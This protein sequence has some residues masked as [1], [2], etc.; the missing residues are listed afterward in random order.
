MGQKAQHILVLI[1]NLEHINVAITHSFKL[2]K[3]FKAEVAFSFFQAENPTV[4]NSLPTDLIEQLNPNSI[5]YKLIEFGNPEKEPNNSIQQLNAIFLITQ[6]PINRINHSY[7][8]NRIFKWLMDARIPTIVVSEKTNPECD[9]KNIFVPIDYR[10]ETKE[11]M[12]WASY[13]GRFNQAVIHLIASN[14]KSEAM[15]RRIKAT[16]LF[17][18]KMY[19]QFTFD[20]KIVKAKSNSNRIKKESF[21]ISKE[22]NSDLIV[23][24]SDPN[25]WFSSY[26]GPKELKRFLLKEEN[27]ILVINPL[28]DYYLPCN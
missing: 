19:E 13:F 8:K 21:Q 16:L 28:K 15:K 20:Y 6:F 24:M 2:A 9:F 1:Q 22:W 17:T 25:A 4:S 5:P 7:K 11:K 26:F 18:K 3:I 14:E 10:R 27:P 12:I 23:L